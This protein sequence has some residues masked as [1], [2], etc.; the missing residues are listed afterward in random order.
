MDWSSLTPDLIQ[1]TLDTLLMVITSTIFTVILGIPLGVLLA[2][3]DKG[4]L[5]RAPGLN[6][7]L[8]IIV[9][10]GRSLPFIILMVAIS[11]FTRLI[12]GT[13]IGAPAAIVPLVVAAVPFFG[14]VAETSLREVDN[15]VI[16]AAR[17]IGCNNWQII[18]K[19]LI[20]EALPALVRGITITFINLLGYSAIAG[21]IGAGGLGDLAIRYGYMRFET[22]VM[23]VTVIL[24]IILVQ[25]IQLLGNFLASLLEKK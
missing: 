25:G 4:G 5:L 6:Q 11:P 21:A 17:A 20:P 1:A 13:T 23:I 14:R 3:T 22:G 9:N 15:G 2:T 18:S 19:V 7:V 10:I 12:A 16:E 24:L 8:G